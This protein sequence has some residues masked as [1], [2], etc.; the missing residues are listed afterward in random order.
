MSNELS[1]ALYEIREL[2][3]RLKQLEHHRKESEI[4]MKC[5]TSLLLSNKRSIDK[6]ADLA[7]KA[8]GEYWDRFK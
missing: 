8:T 2:E 5:F 4:W 7:D 3:K 6:D 1:D